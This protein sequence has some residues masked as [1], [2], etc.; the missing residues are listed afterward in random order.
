M[1]KGH[2]HNTNPVFPLRSLPINS[3]TK[4]PLLILAFKALC[5]L[6]RTYTPT[7]HPSFHTPPESSSLSVPTHRA[8]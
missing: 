6:S 3:T 8:L 2:I 4:S 5:N 7:R 1:L